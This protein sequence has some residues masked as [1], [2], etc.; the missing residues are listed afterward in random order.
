ML[1]MC[2]LNFLELAFYA[3]TLIEISCTADTRLISFPYDA[4][5]IYVSCLSDHDQFIQL[6]DILSEVT[7][8]YS[9]ENEMEPHIKA[10]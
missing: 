6:Y 3:A 2:S 10:K 1:L 9:E 4:K 8:N 5:M 7:V